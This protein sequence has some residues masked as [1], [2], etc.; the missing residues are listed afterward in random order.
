[1]KSRV[2][3]DKAIDLL[4]ESGSRVRLLAVEQHI[5]GTIDVNADHIQ[6]IISEWKK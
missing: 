2:F 5:E 1:L 6:Q 3:P 4:D